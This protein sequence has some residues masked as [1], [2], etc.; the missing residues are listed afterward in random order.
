MNDERKEVA[1]FTLKVRRS[2]AERLKKTMGYGTM[3]G[4]VIKLLDFWEEN[5]E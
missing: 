1:D 5:H 2:T 4:H 3:D